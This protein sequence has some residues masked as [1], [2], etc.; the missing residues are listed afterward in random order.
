MKDSTASENSDSPE[1]D[2]WVL[3]QAADAPQPAE[4]PEPIPMGI[5]FQ[6]PVVDTS[7]FTEPLVIMEPADLIVDVTPLDLQ[8]TTEAPISTLESPNTSP[9]NLIGLPQT[10]SSL[11][12]QT[13]AEASSSN[14]LLQVVT[15]DLVTADLLSPDSVSADSV[16]ADSVTTTLVTTPSLATTPPLASTEAITQSRTDANKPQSWLFR[17]LRFTARSI[18]F[19]YGLV[20][21]IVL[22]AVVTGFPLLQVLV[23]GYLLE[24]S[25]RIAKSGTI[26]QCLPGWRRAARLGSLAIGTAMCLTPIIYLSSLAEAAALVDPNGPAEFRLRLGAMVVA[27]FLVPHMLA[28]W[29]CGGKLR[30]F[31]WPI[32]A[33]FQLAIWILQWGLAAKPTRSLLDHSIGKAWPALVHDLCR[34][35]PIT[36]FFLPA[37]IFK[38]VWKG[39][40]WSHMRDGFWDFIAGM[41]PF[42]LGWLGARALVGSIAWLAL[43]TILLIGGT[44]LPEGAAILSG[45]IG[46]V[47]LAIVCL[48]L[49]TQQTHFAVFGKLVAM[50][51]WAAARDQI[52]RS[53]LRHTLAMILALALAIPL[54]L[55]KIELI[56]PSL[57]WSLGLFF[58]AFSLPARWALGWAYARSSRREKRTWFLWRFP[59]RSFALAPA[60]IFALFVSV[61]RFLSWGGVSG[62]FEHHAFL[63]PAPFTFAF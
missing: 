60:L 4:A 8:T 47:L 25:A 58:I 63:I 26:R 29:F 52:L 16:S 22:L 42:Y 12:P 54:Y 55:L 40:L 2:E 33:P 7:G 53:P 34:V 48:Y 5:L 35:T 37:I 30:Y 3:L 18:E 11:G 31:F 62:L 21:M 41:K 10:H 15:A 38:H 49:P 50:F 36:D 32:L 19:S 9:E 61:T 56:D 57:W 39:T 1:S 51:D 17:W 28:A 23:L 59:I 24:A 44:A 43:P 45:T 6:A 13:T 27:G 14:G 20:S 46:V